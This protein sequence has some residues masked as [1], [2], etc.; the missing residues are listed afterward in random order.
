M[1]A[2]KKVLAAAVLVLGATLAHATP[3]GVPS[4]PVPPSAPRPSWLDYQVPYA[5]E[6]NGISSPH[7]TMEEIADWAQQRAAE[8]LSLTP[9]DY[10]TRL[11]EFK[12]YFIQDGWAQY[13]AYLKDS[14]TI[15]MVSEGGYSS[16]AIVDS[17]PEVIN[18]GPVNGSYHWIV[19]MSVTVSFFKADGRGDTVTTATG[20]HV[21]YMDLGRVESP[22]DENSIAITRWKV[23]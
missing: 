13:A 6:E 9:K 7:R 11:P 2:M 3:P 17:A 23:Q 14:K 16:S 19:R 20:K 15:G 10:K 8:L 5:G 12:K 1:K 4:A 18:H 21:L 22:A